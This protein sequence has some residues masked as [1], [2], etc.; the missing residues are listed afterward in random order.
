MNEELSF[1]V[2]AVL[3]RNNTLQLWDIAPVRHGKYRHAQPGRGCVFPALSGSLENYL[4]HSVQHQ[5][6]LSCPEDN[7]LS[8]STLWLQLPAFSILHVR[9]C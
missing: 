8:S 1:E 2:F 3:S 9:G 4:L 5:R 7:E 6:R